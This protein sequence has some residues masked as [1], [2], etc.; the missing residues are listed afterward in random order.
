MAWNLFGFEITRSKP[1]E[2]EKLKRPSF[3]PPAN[4]DGSTVVAE[5]NFY[6]V[7][8]DVNGITTSESDLIT[9][10]REMAQYPDVAYAVDDIVNEAISLSDDN[11]VVRISTEGFEEGSV[12]ADEGIQETVAA[13]FKKVIEL[14]DFNNNAY[15]IF[16]NWYIDGRIYYHVIIDDQRPGDGIQEVRYIDPRKIRKIKEIKRVQA[17]GAANI[18]QL[19]QLKSEYYVFN[20]SGFGQTPIGSTPGVDT[21]MYGLKIAKDSVVYAHSGVMDPSGNMVLSYLHNAMRILN[22]LKALEDS[23]VIYRFTRAPERR[24][25]YVDV[26]NLPRQKADQY[27]REM[28]TRHKNKLVYD[29]SSGV[30]KDDRRFMTMFEDYW[31]PRR[32]GSKGTQIETLPGGQN[33]GELTDVEHYQQ[34]LYRALGVPT[35]RMNPETSGFTFSRAAEISRDEVKF[36]RFIDRLRR[37]FSTLLFDLLVKQLLLKKVIAKEDVE[38][39]Y[40]GARFEFMTDNHFTEVKD[41]EILSRRIEVAKD[42]QDFAGKYFSH[43]FVRKNIFRQDDDEIDKQDQEILDEQG[44]VRFPVNPFGGTGIGVGDPTF[45]AD[46]IGGGGDPGMGGGVMPGAPMPGADPNALQQQNMQPQQLNS[47]KEIASGEETEPK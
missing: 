44:D 17:K 46:A 40:R 32:E 14:L 4:D 24:V 31:L 42:I 12:F 9:K 34:K 11:D 25:F 7:L 18:T 27:L 33:L 1:E 28:M 43:Q 26:G 8:Y 2:E 6:G 10:Y 19:T 36:S 38:E 29:A 13:E 16:K 3:V 23:L 5:G 15:R 22:A 41:N 37:Q 30:I 45:G 21:T 35:S 47:E 39:F 20:S